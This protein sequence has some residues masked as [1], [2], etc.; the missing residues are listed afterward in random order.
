ML[1]HA[2]DEGCLDSGSNTLSKLESSN[3]E[4]DQ[5]FG[6]TC[7]GE[8]PGVGCRDSLLSVGCVSCAGLL[9]LKRLGK[10]GNEQSDPG[11]FTLGGCLP[12]AKFQLPNCPECPKL[13]SIKCTSSSSNGWCCVGNNVTSL[14]KGHPKND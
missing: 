10:F 8:D 5:P 7:Q 6:T 4:Q 12:K 2:D 1:E 14:K 11:S 9:S 3:R 13:K